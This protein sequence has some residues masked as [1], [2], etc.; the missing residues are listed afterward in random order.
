MDGIVEK[1]VHVTIVAKKRQ[2]AEF[3][4]ERGRTETEPRHQRSFRPVRKLSARL[5]VG[6]LG[7]GESVN[8]PD[9][10]WVKAEA[11]RRYLNGGGKSVAGFEDANHAH[12]SHSIFRIKAAL[13]YPKFAVRDHS[14]V[15]KMGRHLHDL[16][17]GSLKVTAT[18]LHFDGMDVASTR[19][20]HC[21]HIHTA[22][23]RRPCRLKED[24]WDDQ[25][26][27]Q[28]RS[29][30]ILGASCLLGWAKKRLWHGVPL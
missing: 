16:C 18:D 25:L 7:R 6:V 11:L 13:W 21:Q 24:F 5:D 29:D 8:L 1:L 20:V 19:L 14:H 10:C 30:H 2:S 12:S 15:A 27:I 28:E 9:D 3:A 17:H 23:S 26:A 4:D 22:L